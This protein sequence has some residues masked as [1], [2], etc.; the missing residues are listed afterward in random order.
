MRGTPT[1][2]IITDDEG[3]APKLEVRMHGTVIAHAA[4][5][6]EIL[7]YIK[8]SWYLDYRIIYR[9]NRRDALKR[10]LAPMTAGD[11]RVVRAYGIDGAGE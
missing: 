1:D 2:F 4:G 5:A 7:Q 3:C 11:C 10:A 8:N 6:R 9:G